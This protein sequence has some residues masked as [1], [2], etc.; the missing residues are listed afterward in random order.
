MMIPSGHPFFKH[1]VVPAHPVSAW[2]PF[3]DVETNES[4]QFDFLE[5][6]GN[7]G[8]RIL[9]NLQIPLDRYVGVIHTLIAVAS[10][11]FTKVRM[12]SFVDYSLFSYLSRLT[13]FIF[14]PCSSPML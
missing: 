13:L 10:H 9:Q 5:L 3:M 4:L 11:K 2:Q 14:L 1:D 7:L 12:F 6:G 8:W